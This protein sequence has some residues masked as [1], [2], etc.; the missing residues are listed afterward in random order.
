MSAVWPLGPHH[1]SRRLPPSAPFPDSSGARLPVS[2][3]PLIDRDQELAAVITLLRDPGVRLLTLTGPGGVGKTRL[4]IAA[5]TKVIADFADG[6]A[7][8]NLAPITNPDLVVPTIAEALGLRDMGNRSLHDRLVDVLADRRLLLI[9]D[10][11]EQVVTA[12]PQMRDLLGACP[13]VTLLVTSRTRLR[14]SGEREFPVSPLPLNN[15]T[16]VED[17]RR[18][19]AVRLFTERAQ[20]VRPDFRLTAETLAAVAEI[21]SRVDGL[22]L[23]IELA[24]ARMKALPP[25]A[26]L[27]RLGRRLPLL[28]GGAR[29]LPLRQQ[30]MRDT[31]GWSYDLLNDAE[32]ALFRRLAVFVGGFTLEAAE[33]IGSGATDASGELEPLAPLDALEGVTSL[34]EQNLLLLMAGPRDEPRYQMLETVREFARERLDASVEGD[35]V[36]RRHAMF[37]LTLAETAERELVGPHQADW[38]HR[39]GSDH[40]NLR[41][42]L[43]WLA[44]SGEPEAFLRFACSLW[45]FWLYR[46]PYEEGRSWLERALAQEAETSSR[47]RH[48]A[49]YGLGLLAVNQGDVVRAES[50]FDE[51]LAVSRALG[52]STGVAFGWLGLGVV[53]IHLRQFDQ[54][55]TRLEEALAAALR[56][57]DRARA[58]VCAGLAQ[59][60]LGASAY[61]EEV[62]PLATFRFE[63]A[64]RDLREV[65]DTWGISVSI[66]GLGYVAHD[67]GDIARSMA[68]FAEGL[69]LS[70]ELG[71]RHMIAL[72]LDGV[73]C[74]AV[75]RG[76]PER[77]A[78][79]FGAAAALQVASGLLVGPAFRATQ[80]RDVAAARAALGEE[81]F[82]AGWTDG[83]ALPMLAAVTEAITIAAPAPG[84]VSQS[85]PPDQTAPLGLTQRESEVLR[86]LA[87]GLSDRDIAAALSISE[88]TAGNHVLHILQKLK[89]ESRTAAAVFAVRHGLD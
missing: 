12:G 83:T 37:F 13:G 16:T 38:T 68:L 32:Q 73:A 5:A 44:H 55:T 30:T 62:L 34:V 71:D 54:A 28:S 43:D 14:L 47:L 46:G 8:V 9:L 41:A 1:Q 66:I 42:A 59:C 45:R 23:G 65:D 11:F 86:L 60:F 56:L 39:L 3:T 19:G 10:N 74:L 67:R 33:A 57:D 82:A 79:L 63:E 26:L 70:T 61:A 21:V 75:A 58:A 81:A 85:H 80:E 25:A 77:A 20:A 72:A 2:L 27:E 88:R 69:A 7:F 84:S 18:S 40:D 52:D 6:V 29:D 36:H 76:E 24:A 4:A 35:V 15:L 64:L 89:V 48:E 17:A 49:L 53:A 22:P 31:I 78:R 50:C 51:S 87:Q